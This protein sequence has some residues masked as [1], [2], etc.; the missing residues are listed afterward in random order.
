MLYF[1][2][3]AILNM[4]IKIKYNHQISN[5]EDCRTPKHPINYMAR[6]TEGQIVGNAIF[7]LDLK[8]RSNSSGET[9]IKK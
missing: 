9:D 2:M 4:R 3:M 8:V 6:V 1:K 7:I 5:E